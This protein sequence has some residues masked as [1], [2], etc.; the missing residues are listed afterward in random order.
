MAGEVVAPECSVTVETKPSPC[1]DAVAAVRFDRVSK[2]FRKGFRYHSLRED[3][4]LF[5][6]AL[7]HPGRPRHAPDEFHALRSVSFT[8]G[9]GEALGIIGS[10]GAGKSTTL[11][12]IARVTYPDE[13]TIRVRGR[14]A[15]LL[16]AGAGLHPELSGHDNVFLSGAILGMSRAE[17]EGQYDA[18]VEFSELSEFMSMPVK[19]F[20]TGMYVRLGFSVAV[21]T[22]PDVLLVD[23]VLSVGDMGFQA[24]SLDRMLAFREQ[25]VTIVFVSHYLP[26]IAQM[27]DRV[28]WL[29]HGETRMLGETTSV[30][31]AYQEFQDRKIQLAQKTEDVQGWDVGSGDVVIERITTHSVDGMPT[32][33]FGYKEPLLLRIHYKAFRRVEQPYFVVE[34]RQSAG[35]LFMASMYFDDA[36]PDHV[37]GSGVVELLFKELPLLPGVYHIV[38]YIGR[39]ATVA[40]FRPRVMASFGVSSP[41]S[42]YGGVGRI[43]IGDARSM[44]PV[45]VPYEWRVPP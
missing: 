3:V 30:L 17:I 12:L 31:E 21:H 5:V 6:R 44:A 14:V 24:K 40:H 42:A 25:G 20:S 29:E 28:L 34:V 8:V 15:A 7:A 27:C 10:N 16:E 38:G 43:G 9:A 33:R 11:K 4:A 41:L 19:R 36:R 32:D 39:D 2:R 13:G 18:I 45:V 23:E 26:A 37:E 1:P 22:D 35:A